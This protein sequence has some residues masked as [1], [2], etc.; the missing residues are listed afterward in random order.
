MSIRTCLLAATLLTTA[1]TADAAQFLFQYHADFGIVEGQLSGTLRADHNTVDVTAI[2]A[3]TV[4]GVAAPALPVLL[5]GDAFYHFDY[6]G[7]TPTVTFDGSTID[8]MA[9][10]DISC[11][12]GGVFDPDTIAFHPIAV[13]DFPGLPT[14]GLSEDTTP[15]RW[16]LALVPEPASWAMM[17][18]G[19]GLVGAA[20]R[21]RQRLRFAV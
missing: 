17:V 16:T 6:I 1:G 11:L 13:F 14:G 2:N 3:L 5:T 7:R 15:A 21:G 19:F 10:T 9:C 20:L 12:T 8:F 18:V 4:A